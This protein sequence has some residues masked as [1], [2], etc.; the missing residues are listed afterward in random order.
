MRLYVAGPMTGCPDFNYPAFFNAARD[1]RAVGYGPINP[2]RVRPGKPPTTWLEFMRHSLHDLADC[3]GIATLPGW[4]HSRGASL[5]VLVA[6]R[7]GLPVRSVGEWMDAA[8]K[9][10]A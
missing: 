7:L 5:E 3:D 10:S 1:L 6:R 2:A 8:G 4:T 9:R